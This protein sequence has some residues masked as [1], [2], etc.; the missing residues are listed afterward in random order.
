MKNT[1]L[2]VFLLISISGY[3]QIPS[4]YDDVDLT[5]TGQS[6]MNEL[7]DKVTNT[8]TNF[9]SY[10]PGVWD[11]LKLADVNPTNSSQVILIY[12]YD[13]TD[14]DL[15]TDR[16]R[17]VDEN[18]GNSGNWNREHTYPKSLGEPDLGTS[19]PGA[20]AHHLRPSDITANSSRGNKKFA[21][22]SGN[23][24]TTSQGYWYPGDEFKGD[25][26]RMMM[27]M[28]IRYGSR[29]LPTNVG[30]GSS[31]SS[32]ANM[33]DLF[34]DWNAED[35]VSQL[36]EQ[37]NPILEGL[38]GNRNPF[39]DNPAF[40]T[41]I[42]GGAQAEDLF[43]DGGTGDGGGDNELCDATITSFPYNESFESG[44][45]QWKQASTDDF[46]WTRNSGSTASSNTGPS[47]ASAGS[48]YIYMESSSPNYSSKEAILYSPCFDISNA[49]QADFSFQYHLYGSSAMGSL[50]LEISLNGTSW[51]SIWSRSGNQGNSWQEASVDL[52]SYLGSEIQLR[53]NGVTGTTWQGDMA[54]DDISFSTSGGNT[55]GGDSS[56]DVALTI[57]FDNY[58][59]ETS[60]QIIDDNNS[61]V[62]S[63][64]TYGSQSDGSTITLSRS[65]DAGC[66]T[67]I[68]EDEYG[69]GICCSYGYGS[70]EL[71][72]TSTGTTLASG[73]AFSSIDSNAFC[74]TTSS[75]I[76]DESVEKEFTNVDFE[77]FPNP[78]KDIITIRTLSKN[79]TFSIVNH[80]GQIIKKGQV[81]SNTPIEVSSLSPGFYFT[82][83]EEED[84]KQITKKFIKK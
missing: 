62:Y 30:E 61:I 45:G 38:Q 48:Y 77:L 73:G 15:S 53:F 29:C 70:Y 8:H 78:A 17:G 66:Y 63:G 6:L 36:E 24:G 82:I 9:L 56:V 84:G 27:Y 11:A 21:D 46:D 20:D 54:V 26:A 52:S 28:Y 47:S 34:L 64:G 49:S 79:T 39:I 31:V 32:D 42:W 69:D 5:L 58:P 1:F 67:L 12:G 43:G 18:G 23:A 65:L 81:I 25:V 80:I 4:Y 75:K 83:V 40:A 33:I 59:E 60:W 2:V 74:V 10:T 3:C 76:Y 22:G 14:G 19:G 71:T 35:P 41:E 44:F 16:T 72:E 57:T 68:V 51:T 50:S 55:G 13:D 7:S 37:R